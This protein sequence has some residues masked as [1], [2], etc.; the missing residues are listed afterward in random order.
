MKAHPKWHDSP[1]DIAHGVFIDIWE[2]LIRARWAHGSLPE[3]GRVNIEPLN[4]P[5]E[6]SVDEA[7]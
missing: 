5:M 4:E 7:M 3:D 2:T 1:H 6:V